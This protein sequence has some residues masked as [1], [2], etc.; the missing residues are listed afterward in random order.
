MRSCVVFNGDAVNSGGAWTRS[1]RS[2]ALPVARDSRQSPTPPRYSVQN[3]PTSAKAYAPDSTTNILLTVKNPR[4]SHVGLA[5]SPSR[6]LRRGSTNLGPSD[7]FRL[8]ARTPQPT[9]QIFNRILASAINAAKAARRIF[10]CRQ[11]MRTRCSEGH[12]TPSTATTWFQTAVSR[13]RLKRCAGMHQ[14]VMTTTGRFSPRGCLWTLRR[15][16]RSR[17]L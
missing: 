2:L 3:N 9:R 15:R 4:A 8:F 11:P 7:P 6:G 13:S 17:N 16:L 12:S 1:Q 5:D 14:N 10:T